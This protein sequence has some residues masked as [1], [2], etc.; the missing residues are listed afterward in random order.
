MAVN[1]LKRPTQQPLPIRLVLVFFMLCS[2]ILAIAAG[3]YHQRWLNQVK[4]TQ[5]VQ[6][7][8]ELLQAQDIIQPVDPSPQTK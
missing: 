7:Q 4:R 5:R 3:Y 8:L 1:S 6:K 2:V